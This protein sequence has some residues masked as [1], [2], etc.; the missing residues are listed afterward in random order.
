MK[1]YPR[2]DPKRHPKGTQMETKNPHENGAEKDTQK[3]AENKPGYHGTGSAIRK[4][5]QKTYENMK[6]NKIL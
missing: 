3:G 4:R 2:T 1:K 6:V 5:T